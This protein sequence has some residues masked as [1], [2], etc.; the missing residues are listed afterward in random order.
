MQR[1]ELVEQLG[2]L[3]LKIANATKELENLEIMYK[4]QKIQIRK[5]INERA[6]IKLELQEL[7]I[8][9]SKKNLAENKMS[10]IQKKMVE[11]YFSDPNNQYYSQE[12]SYLNNEN[13][14]S[15]YMKRNVLPYNE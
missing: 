2:K 1:K 13:L 14:Y 7:E 10:Q 6:R 5:F 3:N 11:K 8:D 9:N 4:K 12:K 15:D